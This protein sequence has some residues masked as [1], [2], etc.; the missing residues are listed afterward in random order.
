MSE[1]EKEDPQGS[2]EA[3]PADSSPEDAAEPTSARCVEAPT[4][5]PSVL[6]AVLR[7]VYWF[8]WFV[9]LPLAVA[10]FFVWALTPAGTG[11]DDGAFSL[12]TTFVREQPVPV[13]ILSFALAE[14]A[15]WP[16]RFKLPLAE[17]VYPALP[18]GIK[19]E[20]RTEVERA[21]AVLAEGQALLVHHGK[22]LSE[23]AT[24]AVRRALDKIRDALDARPFEVKDLNTLTDRADG[25]LSSHFRSHRKGEGR[26]S[27]EQLALAIFVALVLRAFVFEAF[28]IPSSSMVPTLQVGDHI[29]VNKSSYGPSIPFTMSRLW[30]GMPPKRGDVMVFKFPEKMEQDFIK[31]VIAL[32]GDTLRARAGHPIINGWEVPSCPVG[33]YHYTEPGPPQVQREG[34]LFV[35]YLGDETFLTLYDDMGNAFPEHQGPFHVADGEVWVMGDNRHNSQ[36]SR[37]WWN[38]RGGG[39][40][41]ANIKGRALFVWLSVGV[42]GLDPSRFGTSVMGTPHAPRGFGALQPKIEECIAKRPAETNPPPPSAKQE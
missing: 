42:S 10:I 2:N 40:P 7:G 14:F 39:V 35:E 38:G 5:P 37:L 31:R 23:N 11:D 32:P 36:D 17:Y 16:L 4:P 1:S 25:V 22:E 15:L 18:A 6:R 3:S 9:A 41:F 21:R 8:V 27:I 33:R 29:F 12:L 34:D 28:K 24:S 30:D 19:A 26:E 13:A 20:Y